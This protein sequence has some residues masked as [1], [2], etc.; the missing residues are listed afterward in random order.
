MVISA[1]PSEALT[2]TVRD[3]PLAGSNLCQALPYRSFG[4]RRRPREKW[5]LQIGRSTGTAEWQSGLLIT[6]KVL[7]MN[8]AARNAMVVS[9]DYHAQ[10]RSGLVAG[11]YIVARSCPPKLA[12][13]LRLGDD[14]VRRNTIAHSSA[15]T[16][17][18]NAG[19]CAE[20]I[21][22]LRRW[23]LLCSK[24]QE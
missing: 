5:Y 23:V 18:Q 17:S 20:P 13:V 22:A 9:D 3:A 6:R 2:F 8:T 7:S 1:R 21:N 16:H 19:R 12:R 4:D 24:V 15:S 10:L 11:I 14:P